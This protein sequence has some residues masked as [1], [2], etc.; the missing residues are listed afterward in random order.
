MGGKAIR[1]MAWTGFEQ[2]LSQSIQFLIGII[3][4]RVLLP[5]DYGVM[6]MLAIFIAVANTFLDS[7]FANAL[8]QKKNRTDIDYSTV[9]Y[10]NIVV[11][12]L[13]YALFY[14]FAPDI[15]DFYGM[16]ILTD[17]SR[18]VTLSLIING[19]SIVQTAKLTIDLNFKLQAFST[20]AAVVISGVLGIIMA[21][22]AFGVWALVYQSIA[23]AGVRTAILWMFSHWQPDRIFS[24]E[25]FRGLFPFG[26]KILC[27]GMI[28]TIYQNFYML[29]IGK[30]FN[31]FDVGYFNR[32]NHF[33]QLPADMMTQTVVKVNFPILSQYQD[34]NEM[35]VQVYR[36]LLRF[37]IFILYPVMFGII[38]V[39]SPMVEVLLGA[40]WLPC[41]RILQVL[42]LGY[43]WSPLT[44]IN[45]NL[46]YV[47]GY[48]DLVLKLELIKKP[49]AFFIL[50]A[51]IPLG[52]LGMCA[53]RA[54]YFF[55]A[56]V[57]NCHYTKKILGYGFFSQLKEI[58]PIMANAIVM[59]FVVTLVMTLVDIALFKLAIGIV[60]GCTSYILFA[61]LIKNEFW[62]EIKERLIKK[63]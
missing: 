46:L 49:I 39:A 59:A 17:V 52:V 26:S 51:S 29:V 8:I 27:S 54:F 38:A 16:P 19:L 61:I 4:A 33:S 7:G 55:L 14:F 53:G 1:G 31:A 28:N 47:K 63:L 10:F 11:S 13:L 18:I 20:I 6:G 32:G 58:L 23:S 36:K 25:S 2:L 15:A 24:F 56:F 9:F 12:I 62:K 21:Y 34:D 3:I 41:V 37:P 48:G 35:L 5:E 42:C 22:N 43:I 60:T 45:I 57:L 30:Y 50:F 40:K 44:H